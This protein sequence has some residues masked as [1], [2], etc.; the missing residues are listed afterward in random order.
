MRKVNIIASLLAIILFT[1]IVFAEECMFVMADDGP[2]E[3]EQAVIVKLETW[4]H[5]VEAVPSAELAT[6]GDEDYQ[7]YDFI[8]ASEAVGSSSLAPLK[9]IPIPLLNSEGWASKPEALA[10]SDPASAYNLETEP[11]LIVDE[12]NH[13]LAA[14]FGEE[15]V[16]TLCT[17]GLI[18][19]AMPTIDI[20]P[21]AALESDITQMVIYGVEAGTELTDGD[22]TENRAACV[23]VHEY[24]YLTITEEGDKLYQAAIDWI[25]GKSSAVSDKVNGNPVDFVLDQNYPNPF[26][27]MTSIQFSISET[28]YTTLTVYNHLGKVVETMVSQELNPGT[29]I[30]TFNA[31][32]IPSGVYFYKLQSGSQ[33][34]VNKMILMK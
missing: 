8:F 12:T 29:H 6:F 28:R 19:A 23:A 15:E 18:V 30:F 22:V 9:L 17:E 7:A 27:P 20:I 5:L 24:G 11:V 31:Q 3:A 26:N 21:I 34:Q 16:I 25:L 14:G 1:T 33:A 32:D 13:P 10:W 2:H 4:G